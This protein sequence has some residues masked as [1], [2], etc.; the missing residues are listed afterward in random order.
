MHLRRDKLA[1]DMQVVI[2]SGQEGRQVM[3]RLL[4]SIETNLKLA[5]HAKTWSWKEA[6]P[7]P[8]RP[9]SSL[10]RAAR[11]FTPFWESG[12]VVRLAEI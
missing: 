5:E 10:L 8:P 1:Q 6:T 3:Q 12:G 11:F 7:P 4:E 9:P 2:K